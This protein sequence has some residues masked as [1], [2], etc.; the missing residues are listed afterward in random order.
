MA[1]RRPAGTHAHRRH[2]H[3]ARGDTNLSGALG[4]VW[5][6]APEWTLAFSATRTRRA[7]N[8]QELF[9]DG[10]H[11]GTQAYEI[12]D[13]HLRA[14]QSTGLEATLRR[15]LHLRTAH[16]HGGGGTQRPLGN[17]RRARPGGRGSRRA[18]GLPHGAAQRSLLGLR[19]GGA[20]ASPR[21]PGQPVRRA[22]HRRLRP[23]QG[24]R[25]FPAPSAGGAR[26]RRIAVGL[27]GVELRRRLPARVPPAAGRRA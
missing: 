16:R 17:R 14:E 26:R 12:G 13:D 20:L 23:R 1:G 18:A 15:R 22:F 6:L 5:R 24:G 19:G 11:A 25:P 3:R 9:A 4:A 2:G 10:P 7:P 27:G 21:G 8:A